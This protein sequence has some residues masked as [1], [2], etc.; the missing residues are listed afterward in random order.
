[1][2]HHRPWHWRSTVRSSPAA[3]H[4]RP[5]V[6]G[7]EL[8]DGGGVRGRHPAV[9]VVEFLLPRRQRRYRFEHLRGSVPR[10]AVRRSQRRHAGEERRRRRHV[11]GRYILVRQGSY[12]MVVGYGNVGALDTPVV[13]QFT[14]QALAELPARRAVPGLRRRGFDC[15][16]AARPRPRGVALPVPGTLSSGNERLGPTRSRSDGQRCVRGHLRGCTERP[17]FRASSAANRP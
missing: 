13:E 1:M 3:P 8:L 2:R 16:V 17:A 14:Q 7:Y 11:P 10:S 15:A 6:P 4:R 9:G 5:R 12:L